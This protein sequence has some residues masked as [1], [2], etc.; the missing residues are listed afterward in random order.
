MK[1]SNILIFL[2]LWIIIICNKFEIEPEN[3]D[4]NTFPKSGINSYVEK[5]KIQELVNSIL[6]REGSENFW[7][8]LSIFLI[9]LFLSFIYICYVPIREGC[10]KKRIRSISIDKN[11]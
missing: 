2:F 5:E 4:N 1:H 8:F 11:K 3:N 10:N 7:I 9:A 6:T